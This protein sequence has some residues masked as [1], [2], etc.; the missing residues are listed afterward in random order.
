[1]QEQITP[2]ITVDS[3]FSLNQA[4]SDLRF[5]WGLAK[6]KGVPFHVEIW[7][8]AGAIVQKTEI[9]AKAK[10]LTAVETSWNN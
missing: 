1:M 3:E 5:Y 4:I 10:V 8:E 6:H 7:A 9:P 2:P